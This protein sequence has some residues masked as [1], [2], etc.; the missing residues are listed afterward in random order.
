M[1][2]VGIDPGKSGGLALCEDGEVKEVIP[3][4]TYLTEKTKNKK[5][6]EMVDFV[7]VGKFIKKHNPEVV[8][9]E[10]VG[11]MPGQ[12][13]VSMFSFGWSTGGLHGVCGALE[14]PVKLVGPRA[15][16]KELM[17]DA[18]HEKDDTINFVQT[19]WPTLCLLATKRSKKPHDGMADASAISFYGFKTDTISI[20]KEE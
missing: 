18:T 20:N 16:Q 6:K 12:G 5:A 2:V 9:I 19:K 7:A 17:G 10:R 15:W 11:A 1:K 4:P 8:Y 3:M 13:T 14:I